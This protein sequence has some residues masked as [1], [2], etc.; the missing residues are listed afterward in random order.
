[1]MFDFFKKN[2]SG[3]IDLNKLYWPEV[4]IKWP[5]SWWHLIGEEELRKG[6]QEELHNE[7]GPKHPL[8]NLNPLIF[9]K[10]NNNDDVLVHLNN[11]KFAIVHLLWHG[12]IDQCPDKFPRT[13]II[14]TEADLQTHIDEGEND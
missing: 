12:H 7:I 8:W 2:G 1:M 14:N 10:N 3:L 13:Y 11:D 5:E 9:A 4:S 6:L